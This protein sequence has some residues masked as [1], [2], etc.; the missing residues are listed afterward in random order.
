M[1][2]KRINKKR[3]IVNAIAIFP[4]NKDW[5]AA[6][7]DERLDGMIK[8]GFIEEVQY[9]KTRLDMHA[10]LPSMRS[11]GYRQI[12]SYLDGNYSLDDARKKIIMATRS[13]AKRQMTSLRSD[14]KVSQVVFNSQEDK[15][16]YLNDLAKEIIKN[17]SIQKNT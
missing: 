6:R 7:I 14:H 3:P 4:K 5:L 1:Q 15:D 2:K 17:L 8:N 9:F 11:V 16:S 13:L 10:D 12:W